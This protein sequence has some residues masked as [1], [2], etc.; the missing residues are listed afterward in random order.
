MNAYSNKLSYVPIGISDKYVRRRTGS[1]YTVGKNIKYQTHWDH[2]PE[3]DSDIYFKCSK[4][5]EKK[6]QKKH[7]SASFQ[8][9]FPLWGPFR[10]QINPYLFYLLGIPACCLARAYLSTTD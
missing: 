8:A 2:S 5:T 3:C 6:V 7:I 10:F 1:P 4:A 9:R